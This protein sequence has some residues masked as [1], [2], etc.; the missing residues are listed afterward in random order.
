MISNSR[1]GEDLPA[2]LPSRPSAVNTY[3]RFTGMGYPSP[4]AR[5]LTLRAVELGIDARTVDARIFV[6]RWERLAIAAQ[7]RQEPLDE[8]LGNLG[9]LSVKSELDPE[10]EPLSS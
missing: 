4:S 5:N 6:N 7:I 2:D 3:L 10:S 8:H 9:F 1:G